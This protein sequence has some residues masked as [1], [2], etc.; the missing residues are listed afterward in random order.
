[1][2]GRAS[3]NVGKYPI[4]GGT[5]GSLWL[6]AE[7]VAPC[8]LHAEAEA[9]AV[10][11]CTTALRKFSAIGTGRLGRAGGT[12]RDAFNAWGLSAAAW[13]PDR[14]PATFGCPTGDL[15]SC[16]DLDRAARGTSFPE[17]IRSASSKYS[18]AWEN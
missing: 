14:G 11:R 3:R 13:A 12:L 16:A 7:D 6:D 4:A 17:R 15:R 9:A 18:R 1:M 5:S 2:I 8:W 10:L